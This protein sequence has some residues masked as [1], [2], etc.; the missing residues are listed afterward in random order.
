MTPRETSVNQKRQARWQVRIIAYGLVIVL[1]FS[2]FELAS[3]S[4]LRIFEGYDGTH[5]MN[6]EFDDYKNIRPTP[7]YVNTRGVYHNQQGFRRTEETVKDKPE[8]TYRI[9][10][11]GG[12]TAYGLGSQSRYGKNKYGIIRNDETI[13]HYLEQYLQGKVPGKEVEVINA[14]ITSQQSH[15]HLIYLNQ[16]ILKYHPD[17]VI[18]ID[19]FNDYYPWE[20]GYDQFRDYAYQERAHLFMADPTIDAL[21]GY[22]GWWLFRKSHFVHLA[23]KTLRPIWITIRR[24][25]NQHER[26]K[27]DPQ[28]ALENLAVNAENNFLKMVARNSIILKQAN[29]VGVFTVQPEIVFEQ[30]KTFT[31]LERTILEEMTNEWPIGYSQYKNRARQKVVDLMKQTTSN[32][33]STFIDLTD[34]F[35]GMDEDAFT[36]YCHLTPMGNK[37]LAEYLGQRILAMVNAE[38]N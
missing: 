14:A 24:F 22:T 4:Y 1:S 6:Y 21:V 19:G 38:P 31:D 13:D 17:M 3:Y 20:K 18:F 30:S 23:A 29:V 7:G 33:G 15:H 35:G 16:T 26:K 37:R 25:G 9:F 8:T 12:S 34:P 32:A 27:V 10:V 28:I 2:V 11:M 5:L 36:D